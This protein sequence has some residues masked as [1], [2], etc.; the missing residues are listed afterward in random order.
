MVSHAI[1]SG[2]PECPTHLGFRHPMSIKEK[3]EEP[4]QKFTTCLS[5]WGEPCFAPLQ[6]TACPILAAGCPESMC[7]E[8]SPSCQLPVCQSQC[9]LPQGVS[10]HLL[11]RTSTY[12]AKHL[13]PLTLTKEGAVDLLDQTCRIW[14][15]KGGIRQPEWVLRP[16]WSSAMARKEAQ[17]RR[18]ALR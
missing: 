8:A 13:L 4:P 9:F 5:P 3:Q 10:W 15:A 1:I 2:S 18:H 7:L 11:T 17:V 14:G 16:E 12:W 6:V